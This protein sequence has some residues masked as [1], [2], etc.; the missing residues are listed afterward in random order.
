[1]EFLHGVHH[2]M[3]NPRVHCFDV[4]LYT[5][6]KSG[7]RFVFSAKNNAESSFQIENVNGFCIFF[8]VH[9]HA[10]MHACVD[11]RCACMRKCGECFAPICARANRR[12]EHSGP[13]G[14]NARLDFRLHGQHHEQ[15]CEALSAVGP[16]HKMYWPRSRLTKST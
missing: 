10:C 13:S 5:A 15:W 16:F 14:N 7:F 12:S 3:E 8:R 2:A 9:V 1:M 6:A 4:K 11:V